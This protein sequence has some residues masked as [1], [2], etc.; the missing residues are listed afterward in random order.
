MKFQNHYIIFEWTHK[1]TDKH[2]AICPFDFFKAGSI[3]K[4]ISLTHG[5]S[6]QNTN[7]C[8]WER[9]GSVVECL[10][11]DRGAAG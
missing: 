5:N 10:I 2:N 8:K 7:H 6:I 1:R 9:I 3:K 11:R 4:T